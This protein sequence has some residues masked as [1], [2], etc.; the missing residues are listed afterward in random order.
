MRRYEVKN[1][2][3]SIIFGRYNSGEVSKGYVNNKTIISVRTS[4]LDEVFSRDFRGSSLFLPESRWVGGILVY[5]YSLLALLFY[6]E[7]WV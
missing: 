4:L 2:Y 5:D 6:R 7:I 1:I 3:R